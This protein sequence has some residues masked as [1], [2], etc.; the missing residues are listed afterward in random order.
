MIKLI[1]ESVSFP[2]QQKAT[3]ELE[4]PGSARGFSV[5]LMGAAQGR[6]SSPG[7][8]S[9]FAHALQQWVE[10]SPHGA[11]QPFASPCA[12]NSSPQGTTHH[13]HPS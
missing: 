10:I 13:Q 3:G 9:C 5:Q 2:C 4:D 1:I 8:K 7:Q 12:R 11:E 6:P